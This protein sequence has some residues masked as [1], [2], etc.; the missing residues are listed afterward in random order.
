VD[1]ESTAVGDRA[2]VI[3]SHPGPLA[4][5]ARSPAPPS[6][7]LSHGAPRLGEERSSRRAICVIRGL[8]LRDEWD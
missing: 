3:G 2:V 8:I 5:I 4:G 6:P 1:S 7:S